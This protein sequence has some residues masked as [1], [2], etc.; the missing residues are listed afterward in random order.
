[1]NKKSILFFL[2]GAAAL[3]LRLGLY[4][5]AV[6]ERGLLVPFHY[7][8]ILLWVLTAAAAVMAI[9]EKRPVKQAAPIPGALGAWAFAVGLFSQMMLIRLPDMVQLLRLYQ[10]V[11]VLGVVGAAAVGVCHLRHQKPFAMG[12]AAVCV[13]LCIGMLVSYRSWSS[14]PQIQDY[15]FSLLASVS[16]SLFCFYQAEQSADMKPRSFHAAMGLAALFC[17]MAAL[18]D[19]SWML[20]GSAA[21]FLLGELSAKEG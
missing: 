10:A 18:R 16:L 6:D 8:E 12:Y 1:M 11:T 4:A 20:Y 15:V 17:S 13:A 9:P 2:L 21:A 7:L 19:G 14:C 3:G 5:L